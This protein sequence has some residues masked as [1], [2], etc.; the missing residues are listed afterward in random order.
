VT[1]K[2]FLNLI[3]MN[4]ENFGIIGEGYFRKIKLKTCLLSDKISKSN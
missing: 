4:I 2:G 3:T 1:F